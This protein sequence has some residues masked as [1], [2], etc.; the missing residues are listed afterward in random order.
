[1]LFNIF[2]PQGRQR[3]ARLCQQAVDG[4]L[5]AAMLYALAVS[6]AHAADVQDDRGRTL[7]FDRPATRVVSLLPSLTESVCALGACDRLVGVDRYSNWPA[8]VQR[9]PQLGDGLTPNIEAIVALHP[10]VVLVS[11][12]SRVSDRLAALGIQVVALRTQTHADVRKG[13][14]RIAAITGLPASKDLLCNGETLCVDGFVKTVD[15]FLIV[16][17]FA[18][19]EP[20]LRGKCKTCRIFVTILLQHIEFVFGVTFVGDQPCKSLRSTVGTSLH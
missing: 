6:T 3:L 5:A 19:R 2:A 17:P 16:V 11:E 20:V 15:E 1:M 7:R 18:S 14:T 8:Q 4:L 9:L 12:S 13:L 10:D